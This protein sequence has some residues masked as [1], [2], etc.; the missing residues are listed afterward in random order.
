MDLIPSNRG[1][2]QYCEE[3][4]DREAERL[5]HEPTDVGQLTAASLLRQAA[6]SI[7]AALRTTAPVRRPAGTSPTDHVPAFADTHNQ[8]R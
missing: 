4:V 8:K 3:G 1:F 5:E 6:E 7:R 2:L